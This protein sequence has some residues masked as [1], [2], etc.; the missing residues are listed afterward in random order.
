MSEVQ[1]L[2][3][4]SKHFKVVFEVRILLWPSLV[5][6][7]RSQ[8]LTAL[9]VLKWFKSWCCKV[10]CLCK[11]SKTLLLSVDPPFISN[12]NTFQVFQ[13]TSIIK[14]SWYSVVRTEVCFAQDLFTNVSVPKDY[15][16]PSPQYVSHEFC[17][18]KMS[19]WHFSIAQPWKRQCS[20]KRYLECVNSEL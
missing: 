5:K 4:T 15:L 10:W 11:L 16:S 6:K 1:L 3:Q 19:F 13:G 8:P 7:P 20:L 17:F 12:L 2:R 9:S 18:K 14:A